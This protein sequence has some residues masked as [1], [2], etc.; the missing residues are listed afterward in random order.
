MFLKTDFLL[1]F[2]N[3]SLD[4]IEMILGCVV[5]KLVATLLT[6][7]LKVAQFKITPPNF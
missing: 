3:L 7:F 6:L 1:K 4:Y 5:F 2:L